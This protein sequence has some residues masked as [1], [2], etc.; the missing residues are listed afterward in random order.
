[1]TTW[2]ILPP[3]DALCLDCPLP[4][5][6]ERDPRCPWALARATCDSHQ[7]SIREMQVL[8]YLDSHPETWFRTCD[9]IVALLPIPAPTVTAVL[10]KLRR[11]G[12]VM[13]RGTGH[14]LELQVVAMEAHER[15]SD[16]DYQM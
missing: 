12:R 16:P 4:R 6:N 8:A 11:E 7:R 2:Y 9:V 1:M 13:E 3:I 15:I 14:M 5:C 10:L